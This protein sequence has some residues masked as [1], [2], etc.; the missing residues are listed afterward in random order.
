MTSDTPA[1]LTSDEPES[2]PLPPTTLIIPSRNR[3]PL[4]FETVQ[5]VLDGDEV[6]TEIVIVDQSDEP[7][8]QLEALRTERDCELR[9]RWDNSTGL[10]RA[11]NVGIAAAQSEIIAFTHDDVS[12]T[13]TW[14]GTLVRSLLHAGE[15]AVVTGRVLPERVSTSGG[16]VPSTRVDEE[17]VVYDRRTPAGVLYP[18][19]MAMWRSAAEDVGVFDERLGPGTRFPA[20]EDNDFSYRLLEADYWIVYDPAPALYHRAWRSDRDYLPLRWSYGRGQGGFYGKHIGLA[21]RYVLRSLVE[22]VLFRTRRLF[23]F[24]L[25]N[26]RRAV[27]EVVYLSGLLS[28]TAEWLLTQR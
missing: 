26:R 4:L 8:A 27:G 28:G 1:T 17:R 3:G 16:F 14:F 12:V 23:R 24:L 2:G 15:K 11:N 13:P 9:Y 7:N 5:S 22:E 20:A 25:Q 18:M 21:D 10:S 19:N 6:P